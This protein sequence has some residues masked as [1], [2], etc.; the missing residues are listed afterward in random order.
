[1]VTADSIK[2]EK[3]IIKV[4]LSLPEDEWLYDFLMS[5]GEKVTILKLTHVREK[6]IKRY[7]KALQH[8]ARSKN[9]VG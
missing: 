2:V 3:G 8:N 7:K 9:Y 6:M 1:M 4:S 5:F